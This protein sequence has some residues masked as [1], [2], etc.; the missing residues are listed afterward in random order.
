[1]RN[2]IQVSPLLFLFAIFFLDLLYYYRNAVNE[3][4][5]AQSNPQSNMMDFFYRV[6]FP[7]NCYKYN[8]HGI[9]KDIVQLSHQEM[10]D[11]HS[12]YYHPSN[13]QA[14]CYGPQAYVND[15]LAILDPVLANFDAD[16]EL[17][18]A[19]EVAWQPKTRIIS[20]KAKIP[21]ASIEETDDFRLAIAWLLND[22]DMDAKTQVAWQL[23]QELLIGTRVAAISKVVGD[24][25]LGEDI[26]GGLDTT[27][28]QWSL[29][30]GVSGITQELEATTAAN[31]INDKLLAIVEQGFS[32]N[33]LKA[34]LNK[35]EYKVCTLYFTFFVPYRTEPN[36]GI[37]DLP[38]FLVCFFSSQHSS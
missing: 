6:L 36:E 26:I 34:A 13:G 28:K 20:D 10:I 8:P 27:S 5:A 19:T 18:K 24:L 21:Y 3:A 35:M 7:E 38:V 15:C 30:L 33:A 9:A 14:F 25:N 2:R 1:M 22:A 31:A 37:V 16:P 29:I 32:E 4:R 17:R 11:F 23:I 12:K